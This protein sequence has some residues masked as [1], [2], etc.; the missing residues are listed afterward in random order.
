MAADNYRVSSGHSCRRP[1]GEAGRARECP[2]ALHLLSVWGGQE[3]KKM[4]PTIV[5]ATIGAGRPIFL[6]WAIHA[7][8]G[9][10][11]LCILAGV[12]SVLAGVP[13]GGSEPVVL[14]LGI[15]IG[16]AVTFA[17]VELTLSRPT[18]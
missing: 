3:L 14:G 7:G 17:I 13:L 11:V 18:G 4:M 10:G 9:L 12:L 2:R 8:L 5:R 6:R 1:G 16:W 15:A